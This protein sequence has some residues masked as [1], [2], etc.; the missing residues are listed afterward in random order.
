MRLGGGET[1]L[2]YPCMW[3]R[4]DLRAAAGMQWQ[5]AAAAVLP[6]FLAV[7]L[8]M[9]LEQFG[10]QRQALCI[11]PPRRPPAQHLL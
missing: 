9:E 8:W 10:P 6:P 3:L 5:Q 4:S 1:E 11:V 2:D 7:H